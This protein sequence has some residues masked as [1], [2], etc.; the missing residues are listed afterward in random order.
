MKSIIAVDDDRLSLK[1]MEDLLVRIFSREDR[2]ITFQN[3]EH[4]M[5]YG[6]KEKI[7]IAF[8]DICMDK[9]NGLELAEKLKYYHPD[10]NI[11][12]VSAF[13]EYA[14]DAFRLRASGYICKPA[15]LPAVIFELKNLR[16]P[17]AKE[18]NKP[19]IQ[20]FGYFEVFINAVPVYFRRRKS[21]ELLAFL[22]DRKGST[23]TSSEIASVLWE[24]FPL[25]RSLQKYVATCI[26]DM[27]T[28]LANAGISHI[29]RKT[30]GRISLNKAEVDCDYYRFLDGDPTALQAFTNEYMTN[31]SWAEFTLGT[32]YQLKT[33]Q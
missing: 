30:K 14:L 12:F 21:K 7:D 15:T 19:V 11:I 33:N 31:Y 27:I 24:E 9:M 8:L 17:I 13:P 25:D 10:L 18:R 20:T 28:D 5:Q 4:A 32:L 1:I 23:V 22:V 16:N 26:S 2:I 6:T 3:P 29:I